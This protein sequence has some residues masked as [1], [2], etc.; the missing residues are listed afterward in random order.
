MDIPHKQVITTYPVAIKSGQ[1]RVH[2]RSPIPWHPDGGTVKCP[3]CE[4][5]F[6]VTQG[7]PND[8]LLKT[9][10]TQHRRNQEHPD[11]IS[12]EANW[13]RIEDCDCHMGHARG[14]VQEI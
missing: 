6:I 11:C 8:Q 7:F 13:T 14:R 2:V 9:L 4:T 5:V 1:G 10:E 3:E 12:S